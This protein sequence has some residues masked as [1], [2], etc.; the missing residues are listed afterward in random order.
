MNISLCESLRAFVEERVRQRRYGT[1]C[2]YVRDA[3]RRD[4]DRQRLRN[5][6]L[7]C[8]TSEPCPVADRRYFDELRDEAELTPRWVCH[9]QSLTIW[10]ASV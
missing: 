6:L 3:I 1:T 9:V 2:E 7:A 4:Q 5:L 8:A 10:N